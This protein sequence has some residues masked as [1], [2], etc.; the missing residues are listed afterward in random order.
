ML[1]Y[2]PNGPNIVTVAAGIF[3]A[4]TAFSGIL[5]FIID[6]VFYRNYSSECVTR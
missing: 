3:T 1:P 2:V 5:Y 4:S 6:F